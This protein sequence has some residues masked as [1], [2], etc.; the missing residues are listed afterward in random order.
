MKKQILPLKEIQRNNRVKELMKNKSE[1][2]TIQ[3]Y[4][5][6]YDELDEVKAFQREGKTRNEAVELV[7]K[8]RKLLNSKEYKKELIHNW[9]KGGF[10]DDNKYKQPINRKLY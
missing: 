2:K 1:R 8:K 4:K 5:L 7:L 6:T 10:I 3:P 9:N